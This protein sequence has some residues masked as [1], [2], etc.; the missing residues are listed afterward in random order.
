MS[1]PTRIER[2]H[3]QKL[4]GRQIIA[5][6]WDELDGQALPILVLTGSGVDGHAAT[7]TLL[8]D[9]QGNAPGHLDHNL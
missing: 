5:I 2:E 4:V 1:Q 9:P 3:Y 6:Y 7:A 8:A